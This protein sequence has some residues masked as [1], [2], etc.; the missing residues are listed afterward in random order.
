MAASD[1]TIHVNSGGSGAAFVPANNGAPV[2]IKPGPGR[3]M[4]CVVTAVGTA[5]TKIY[6]NASAASGNV[7]LA[8]PASPTLGAVYDVQ[9]AA[10][11]GITCDAITNGSGLAVGY[12]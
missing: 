6:D 7:L 8:I 3:L 12:D 11:N 5:A 2:V 1:Q 4:K 9:L 10:V